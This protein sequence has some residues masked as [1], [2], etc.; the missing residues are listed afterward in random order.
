[1]RKTILALTLIALA[2]PAAGDGYSLLNIGIQYA[3]DEAWD[4]AILWL[5]KAIDAGDLLPDQMRA[6]RYNRAKAYAASGRSG[7]AIPDFDA[8]LALTPDDVEILT[9]RAFA[10]VADS[11]GDQA[12]ADLKKAREKN[13]RT[14]GSITSSAL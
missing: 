2:T 5:G 9:E 8:A 1:M 6:A 10:Y 13:P 4:N 14:S 12:L 7:T 3:N 11:H